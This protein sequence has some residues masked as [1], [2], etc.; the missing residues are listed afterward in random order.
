MGISITG[1]V[2]VP[3]GKFSVGTAVAGFSASSVNF[4]GT[5]DFLNRGAGL[6]GA[7][8]G[9]SC[10]ISV[11]FN[12]IGGDNS[13]L[14]IFENYLT[15]VEDRLWLRRSNNN[16][17]LFFVNTIDSAVA[18]AF[19]TDNLYDTS[20]NTGWHHA[21][22]SC[23]LDATPV[24]QIYI[25]DSLASITESIVPT[26]ADTLDFTTSDWGIGARSSDELGGLKLNADLSELWFN[27]EHVDISVEANRRKFIDASGK[28]ADLGS[29]GSTATGTQPLVYFRGNAT[30]WNAGTNSGSG[31]DFTMTG[32]VTDAS[33]SPSD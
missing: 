6:T 12:I 14:T 23:Q 3:Q 1:G 13:H 19:T 8:D 32:E 16:K 18:W 2:K 9:V 4:D 10:T 17:L 30:V 31:G 22:I 24:G 21:L 11:W 25:D 29:D 26:D 28:P 15:G 27:T 5:N 33:T 7:S 20:N